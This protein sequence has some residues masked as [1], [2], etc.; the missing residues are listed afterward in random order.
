MAEF[1][2]TLMERRSIRNY[3]DQ[4]VSGEELQKILSAVQMSPSWA[5]CQCWEIVVVSDPEI[6]SA[7]GET[8]AKGNPAAK[9]FSRAPLVLA[10]VAKKN[11]SGFYKGVVTTKFG[12]WFMF[13]MGICCQSLCLAAQDLGLGTVVVGLF[14]QDR[15][16]AILKVPEGFDLVSLVPLGHPEKVPSAPKRRE[17]SEFSHK[18]V[19]GGK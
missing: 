10:L 17:I 19:F 5:N 15:A 6:K 14:D 1:F 3:T 9:C 18:N 7:L 16:A 11:T 8:L 4:P 12:D 13:D 2:Q